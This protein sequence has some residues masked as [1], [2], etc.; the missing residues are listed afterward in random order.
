MTTRLTLVTNDKSSISV[1]AQSN[2]YGANIFDFYLGDTFKARRTATQHINGYYYTIYTYTGLNPST[3]YWIAVRNY[4]GSS[5]VDSGGG[6]FSTTADTSPPSKPTGLYVG[7]PVYNYSSKTYS[8][9]FSWNEVD[10]ATSYDLYRNG[11]YYTNTT[12]DSYVYSNLSPN[13]TYT[14]GVRAKNSYGTSSIASTS[15]TMPPAPDDIAPVVHSFYVT[16]TTKTSISCSW[17]I[18]DSG[19]SGLNSISLGLYKYSTGKWSWVSPSTSSTSYTFSN[20]TPS[21]KYELAIKATD[22]EGNT[23]STS[24]IDNIWTQSDNFEWTYAKVSG[25]PV[26]VRANE[27]TSF[28]S[29]INEK[30]AINGLSNYGFTTVY[31]GSTLTANIFNQSITAINAI[32][33]K[34]GQSTQIAPQISGGV[35]SG[36]IVYAWYFENIKSALNNV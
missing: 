5:W 19:G 31:A 13:T 26:N 24:Y 17:Y 10:N 20:L 25:E 30:R 35:S 15:K 27:W 9:L 33:S 12:S 29:K 1:K 18:T 14:F 34:K 16:G 36:D 22:G 28:Q 2:Y 7:V 8:C 6:Y 32:Y 11:R 21:S 3:D 23:S 4:L